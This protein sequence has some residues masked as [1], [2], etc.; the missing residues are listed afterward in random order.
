[1]LTYLYFRLRRAFAGDFEE[2]LSIDCLEKDWEDWAEWVRTQ[3]QGSAPMSQGGKELTN[4]EGCE[5]K[6]WNES[7]C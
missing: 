5:A 1:M 7:A 6:Y 2:D 3:A 4:G